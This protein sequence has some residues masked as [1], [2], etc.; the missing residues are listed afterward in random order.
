MSQFYLRYK[1]L[2]KVSISLPSLP[3]IIFYTAQEN[4]YLALSYELPQNLC[5]KI[6]RK[7]RK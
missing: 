1:Q 3:D 5:N 2:Y 7:V 6:L 4:I